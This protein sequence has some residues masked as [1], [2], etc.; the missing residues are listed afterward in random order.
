MKTIFD[1]MGEPKHKRAAKFME[2]TG[3]TTKQ[4]YEM[5]DAAPEYFPNDRRVVVTCAAFDLD[6]SV[7]EMLFAAGNRKLGY[8]EEHWA[9][10]DV[11]TKFRGQDIRK[12]NA[13]LASLGYG[14][15]TD[16]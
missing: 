15:L 12:R 2:I 5:K 13:Y 14:K 3:L 9:F 8:T 1:I 7:C 16:D 11:L 10:R 6:I 4:Y